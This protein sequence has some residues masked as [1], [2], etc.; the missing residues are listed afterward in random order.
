MSRD[1][2]LSHRLVRPTVRTPTQKVSRGFSQRSLP[3]IG[4]PIVGVLLVLVLLSWGARPSGVAGASSTAGSPHAAAQGSVPCSV[5][6]NVGMPATTLSATITLGPHMTIS[7]LM[8]LMTPQ[9]MLA[10]TSMT[11]SPGGADVALLQATFFPVTQQVIYTGVIT[12]FPDALPGARNLRI[13]I[14]PGGSPPVEF[15][16]PLAFTVETPEERLQRANGTFRSEVAGALQAIGRQAGVPV[17]MDNFAF[18]FN[19]NPPLVVNAMV[20]SAEGLTPEQLARGADLLLTFL[21]LPEGSALP[22]GFYVVRV[23]RDPPAGSWWAQFRDPGGRMVLQTPMEVDVRPIEDE[24]QK[25]RYK[26]TARGKLVPPTLIIDWHK[27]DKT[28]EV[29]AQIELPIGTG[30]P[31]A[32]PLPPA[33]QTILNAANAFLSTARDAIAA[34]AKLTKADAA[35]TVALASWEDDRVVAWTYINGMER[36]TIEELAR[37]RETILT[38]GSRKFWLYR[39]HRDE[40]GQWLV[41]SLSPDGESHT[42]VAEVSLSDRP[43]DSPLPILLTSIEPDDILPTLVTP[44][45]LTIKQPDCGCKGCCVR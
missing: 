13:R 7:Q 43:S 39:L 1:R 23:F 38:F 30:G 31:D 14:Q 8:A 15:L 3:A 17:R 34:G 42:E 24:V 4:L 25:P 45:G 16:C 9:Q 35:R 2:M 20:S 37:G 11:F 22:S 29:D 27:K 6:P 26:L 40:N 32:A 36:A 41:T 21:R 19:G 12:I 33:G 10:A 28:I 18:T 5:A 44:A